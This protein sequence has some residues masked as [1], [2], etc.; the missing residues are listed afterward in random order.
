[1]KLSLEIKEPNWFGKP[2]V[3]VMGFL[4]TVLGACISIFTCLGIASIVAGIR[5]GVPFLSLVGIAC[6]GIAGLL[7]YF[8]PV[9]G[10]NFFV[11][12][13]VK[14]GAHQ[15]PPNSVAFITQVS[16]SPRL[17]CGLRGFLEDADDIGWLEIVDEG[18]VFNGDRAKVCLP[19]ASIERMA[20]QNCGYRMLWMA[21][22][23]IRLFTPV[24][25]GIQF[26]E[27]TERDS[28]TI[29]TS[30]RLCARLIREIEYGMQRN[31]TRT[32]TAN[33]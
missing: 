16:L 4:A 1:M 7:L 14:D 22:R 19:F 28:N 30:R 33:D 6:F 31:R 10:M 5:A 11:R 20:H 25:E 26:I 3:V 29:P 27:F 15:P 18:L 32:K 21:G 8:L 2:E 13:L 23:R 9:V 24:F 17:Y 12:H